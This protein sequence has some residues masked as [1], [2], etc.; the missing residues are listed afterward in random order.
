MFADQWLMS[1]LAWAKR[2]NKRQTVA[3]LKEYDRML[4]EAFK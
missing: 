4:E 3:G 2:G 1:S